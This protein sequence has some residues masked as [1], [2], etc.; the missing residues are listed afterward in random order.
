MNDSTKTQDIANVLE[1]SFPFRPFR[2][3][4]FYFNFL[5]LFG[6]NNRLFTL[7]L[8][9][10]FNLLTT[11][12]WALDTVLNGQ[13][14]DI[15][16]NMAAE[17]YVVQSGGILR[18][19][20]SATNVGSVTINAG[21]KLNVQSTYTLAITGN[22][23]LEASA[24]DVSFSVL[25]SGTITVGG[26][27]TYVKTIN[28]ANWYFLAFPCDIDVP[29]QIVPSAGSIGTNWFINRYN[30]AA[31]ANNAGGSSNWISVT[32]GTLTG[33]QGYIFGLGTG[34]I[35][36]TFTLNASVLTE[37]TSVPVA[38]NTGT[39]DAVHHGWNLI[40]APNLSKYD[41]DLSGTNITASNS[42][43]LNFM[44]I[45]SAG[46][47]Y[48]IAKGDYDAVPFTAF[49]V[50]VQSGT[51]TVNFA[52]AGRYLAPSSAL[53]TEAL[54]DVKVVVTSA[55]G[56]DNTHLYIDPTESPAYQI[57]NDLQK[58]IATGTD[59]PQIYSVLGGE[60]YAFN[61]LPIESVQNLPLSVYTK[62]AG[63][64]TISSVLTS[65]P[66]IS[67]LL[68]TDNTEHITTDLVT[69]SYTYTALAGTESSRFTITA[70]HVVTGAKA[71]E[72]SDK[73]QI[74][75][76]SHKLLVS[77]IA[78]KSSVRVVDALGRLVASVATAHSSIEIP[79]SKKG[80]Y[81]VQI[82]SGGKSWSEKVSVQ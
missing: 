8:F 35:T 22:L 24:A 5:K 75:V 54:D 6:I 61:S 17:T 53:E 31:R 56:N 25:N 34:T 72:K 65:A 27:I 23:V 78:E 29:T 70:E 32:S 19:T 9:V 82:Q 20:G 7:G 4:H 42:K 30:G 66:G 39:A 15:S 2:G 16:G 62:T 58:M 73:P 1:C 74:G 76:A 55:T 38:D 47:Y 50:Q 67:Q 12:V 69:S 36:L 28:D 63:S 13:T 14:R 10:I 11:N 79:V 48:Q 60:N 44:S 51:T 43:V 40:G 80:I 81:V 45:P 49:F 71:I 52:S 21:G 68:L 33:K 59:K 3:V 57:G 18:L 77:N 26:T 37:S 41:G 46:S 64:V